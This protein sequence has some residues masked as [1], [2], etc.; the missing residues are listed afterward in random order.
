L[1]KSGHIFAKSAGESLP[2]LED[3]AG[4]SVSIGEEVASP[5]TVAAY[6]RLVSLLRKD[7][8]TVSRLFIT[9]SFYQF[10]VVISARA[11]KKFP[12]NPISVLLTTSY[13]L[14]AQVI[15]LSKVLDERS[16]QIRERIDLRVPGN[17]YFY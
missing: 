5:E 13:P 17:V 7:G 16:E 10:G 8:L 11:D 2:I 6:E 15:V 12:N 9:E 3:R 4:K 1:D 14:E